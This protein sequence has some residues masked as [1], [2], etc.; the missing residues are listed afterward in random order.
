MFL[1]TRL[2]WGNLSISTS[3]IKAF[4]RDTLWSLLLHLTQGDLPGLGYTSLAKCSPEE[5]E[6]QD[7]PSTSP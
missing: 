3:S 6:E 1:R 4:E 5:E 2:V 7:V